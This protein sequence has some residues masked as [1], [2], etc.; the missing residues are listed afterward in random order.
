MTFASKVLGGTVGATCG[1]VASPQQC[2]LSVH[3]YTCM[4]TH[5]Y[6]YSAHTKERF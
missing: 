4:C 1:D 2:P 5:V 3:M 6:M